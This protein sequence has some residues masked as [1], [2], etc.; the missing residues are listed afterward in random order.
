MAEIAHTS[1]LISSHH[2]GYAALVGRPNVGKST[3]LNHLVGE[4]ISIT[5]RKPQTTRHR[6]LG[7]KT[8]PQAQ[9]VYVDT[10]GIHTEVKN[11]LNRY[12]NRTATTTLGSVDVVIFVVEALRWNEQDQHVLQ[13]LTTNSAIPVLLAVNKIDR[14]QDKA[15][16]L[17]YLEKMASLFNFS[18]IIPLSAKNATN[19]APLEQRLIE[20]LPLGE[21][22]FP[23]DQLTDR[24][25]R[26]I[27][28]EMVR[29]KL[30]RKLGDELPYSLSV[31]IERFQ[32][33]EATK[34]GQAPLLRINALIWV[35]RLG[36]KAIVIGKQGEMLKA[37]GTEAR[38]DMERL[39][40]SKVFLELWVKIKSGWADDERALRQLGYREE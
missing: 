11:A 25:E 2:M 8:L 27:A 18:D 13:Y 30:M 23:V 6:L 19:L 39:F 29:E 12:M 28:A 21:A 33:E 26:F 38:H 40:G 5:S 7:V 9:I 10:P 24:S 16:L 22:L 34:A 36:Q 35:E 1:A 32:Y 20:L 37:V 14:L 4:K 31:E 17:P 3:L 15:Q